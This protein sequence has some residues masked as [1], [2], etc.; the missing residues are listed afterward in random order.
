MCAMENRVEATVLFSR[1]VPRT[2]DNH[3]ET[4]RFSIGVYR[5]FH[6][7]CLQRKRFSMCA[8][9]KLRIDPIFHYKH[10]ITPPSLITAAKH[11]H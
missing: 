8:I 1:K 6:F 11:Q 4:S 3:F 7:S 2:K 9:P 5:P 10:A